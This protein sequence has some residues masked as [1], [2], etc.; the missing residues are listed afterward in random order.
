MS[1]LAGRALDWA[2][3]AVG[4]NPQLSSCLPDF[5][6]EFQRVFDHPSQGAD[7]AGRLHSLQQGSQSVADNTLE[8]RTLAAESGWDNAALRS[9]YRRGLLE[10]LKD[11]LVRDHPSSLNELSTLAHRLDDRLRERRLERAQWRETPGRSTPIHLGTSPLRHQSSSVSPASGPG[12]VDLSGPPD[13]DEPMQLGRSRLSPG[14][15]EQRFREWLCLYC[16]G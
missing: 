4:R 13:A 12:R 7:A 15:R 6:E 9:A 3:A 10:E 14:V 1:S 11:L 2:V 8:F 16:G 5:L